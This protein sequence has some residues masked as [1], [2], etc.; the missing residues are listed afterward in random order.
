MLFEQP[1]QFGSARFRANDLAVFADENHGRNRFD[2]I[3]IGKI[4]VIFFGGY[5][6]GSGSGLPGKLALFLEFFKR[7]EVPVDAVS[8]DFKSGVVI[9]FIKLLNVRN[10]SKT[11]RAPRRPEIDQDDL[12]AIGFPVD[13]GLVEIEPFDDHLIADELREPEF[14]LKTLNGVLNRLVFGILKA[15]DQ[16]FEFG[17]FALIGKFSAESGDGG[18]GDG[19]LREEVFFLLFPALERIGEGVGVLRGGGDRDADT[20]CGAR[21]DRF[22]RVRFGVFE[23]LIE[24]DEFFGLSFFSKGRDDRARGLGARFVAGV[25]GVKGSSPDFL[26]RGVRF[27]K[28]ADAVVHIGRRGNELTHFGAQFFLRLDVIVGRLAFFNIK[29]RFVERILFFLF[30]GLSVLREGGRVEFGRGDKRGG[31]DKAG[32]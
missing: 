12:A 7:F 20:G 14:A 17:P 29:D 16:R 28:D 15:I 6:E 1:L 27:A 4:D 26:E 31:A 2:S 3:V 5:G 8:E 23:A 30:G 22:K 25:F 10:F 21:G 9:L 18:P 19:P 11:R 13:F 32:A 24:L